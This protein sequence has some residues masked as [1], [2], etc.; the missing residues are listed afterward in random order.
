MTLLE[1]IEQ[2]GKKEG[3]KEGVKEG[4][5]LGK[6]NTLIRLLTAAFPQFTAAD[7]DR[8]R[9][10]SDQ[11][12]NELTDALATHHAWSKIKPIVRH[13]DEG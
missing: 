5:I 1:L 7:A 8:V 11:R 3:L 13:R 9:K 10:F 2:R 12:L 6:S 4:E